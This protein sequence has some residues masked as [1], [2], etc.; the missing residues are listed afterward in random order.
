ML[1]YFLFKSIQL[2]VNKQDKTLQL[3]LFGGYRTNH[4]QHIRVDILINFLGTV[5]A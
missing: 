4:V 5:L 1:K 3:R 2:L